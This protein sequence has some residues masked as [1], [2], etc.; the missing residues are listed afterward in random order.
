VESLVDLICLSLWR[1]VE[2]VCP[3][4]KCQRFVGEQIKG[5]GES[6]Q[7]KGAGELSRRCLLNGHSKPKASEAE[8]P[9]SCSDWS[10]IS[11]I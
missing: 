4:H 7:I 5:D 3:N 6:T 9:N 11:F 8:S 1:A 2:E 10:D